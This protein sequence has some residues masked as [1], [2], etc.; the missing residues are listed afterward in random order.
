[1][2]VFC[3]YVLFSKQK[4]SFSCIQ[5][6]FTIVCTCWYAQMSRGKNNNFKCKGRIEFY[7]SNGKCIA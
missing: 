7:L 6:G 5:I 3:F 2:R 4:K 1:M